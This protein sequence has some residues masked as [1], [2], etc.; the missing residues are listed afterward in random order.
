MSYKHLLDEIQKIA[1][2]IDLSAPTKAKPTA[3]AA[4]GPKVPAPTS[5]QIDLS[6]KPSATPAAKTYTGPTFAKSANIMK[7]QKAMKDLAQTVMS[8]ANIGVMQSAKEIKDSK[9]ATKEQKKA[10]KGFADFIAEQYTSELDDE[11]K[12]V[13]WGADPKLKTY[14]Q[15]QPTESKI[16]EMDAVMQTMKRIGGATSEFKEDGFWGFRTDNALKNIMG[17]AYA[18]LTLEGDFGIPAS[19][20]YNKGNWNVLAQLLSGYEVDAD[21]KEPIGLP[22][23]ERNSRAL[24]IVPHIVAIHK[25]YNEVRN[26]ILS[27]PTYRTYIEGTNKFDIT[28]QEVG[29]TVT[30]NHIDNAIKQHQYVTLSVPH[31]E[32]GQEQSPSNENVY[33]AF[34]KNTNNFK[35]FMKNILKCPPG[36]L[37]QQVPLVY[38][39][40][41]KQLAY[42]KP[43]EPSIETKI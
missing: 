3:P 22:P 40:I 20:T 42:A 30:P 1:Q 38:N 28:P 21:N 33:L 4:A 9:A 26:Y 7:M 37:D 29:S 2:T 15:K 24:K 16:Y 8:D 11:H 5:G 32:N 36:I 14:Q 23:Q 10:K 12:G 19:K 31:W 17:F 43:E 6:T 18:L 25:L 34:L 27:Q 35:N 13:T 41:S 39:N